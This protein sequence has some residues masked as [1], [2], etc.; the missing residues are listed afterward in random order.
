MKTAGELL[1]EK[2]LVKE[3]TIEEVAHR[4]KVKPEYLRALE[5]SDFSSLP[6]ATNTKGFLKNYARALRLNPDTILA[7]FRRDFEEKKDGEIIPRGLVDPI[8]NKPKIISANWILG[9]GALVAFLGFLG[10]QLFSW[11]SLPKLEI[12]QPVEGEVYGEKITV[13]GVTDRDAVIE[14]NGQKV[15]VNQNGEFSLDLI[16]AS[17]THSVIV[18]SVNRQGKARMVERSFQVS[19]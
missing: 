16:F 15:I 4:I 19:K 14:I 17:G 3:L 9:V 11:W 18:K 5:Q 7:M 12:L 13:K 2:R 10:F 6:G 1:R 8:A